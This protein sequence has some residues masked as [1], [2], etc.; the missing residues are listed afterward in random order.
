[1]SVFR[2]AEL[3]YLAGG[4]QLG[5]LATVGADGTPHVVP[6]G[7]TWD[8]QTGTART[9]ARRTSRKA[10]HAAAGSRAVLCSFDGPRWMTLEGA[11]S[12]SDDPAVLADALARYARR[13][14]RTPA[15]DPLRIVIEVAVDRVMASSSLR[16]PG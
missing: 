8:A 2:E 7:F 5:R 11:A 3:R 6:V 13:Y 12:V 15:P 14:E 4:R 10:R 9:T 16:L 1:V